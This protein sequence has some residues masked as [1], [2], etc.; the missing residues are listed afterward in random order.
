MEVI[1]QSHWGEVYRNLHTP[2]LLIGGLSV[3]IAVV[4]STFSIL[5]HLKWYTNPSGTDWVR[6]TAGAAV[7][8]AVRS[9]VH[10]IE[11]FNVNRSS[12]SDAM[13]P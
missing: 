9:R 10:R 2:G 13:D 4:L 3:L 7:T 1:R 8:W 6:R 12:P 5:Q 11:R